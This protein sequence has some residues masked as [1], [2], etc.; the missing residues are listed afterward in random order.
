MLTIP[1]KEPWFSMILSGEKKEEY[2]EIKRYW[3]IRL[4]N[5]DLLDM[6]G[7]PNE[8]VRTVRFVNGYGKN[9]PSF[10]AEVWADIDI[11]RPEWGAEKGKTYYVLRI[12]KVWKVA[13]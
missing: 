8:R 11:G 1:I 7:K 12:E 9:R 10:L 3:Q 6:W 5:A 2:R 13:P 4:C